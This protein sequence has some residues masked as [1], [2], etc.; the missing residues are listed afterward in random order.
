M[1]IECC[2]LCLKQK[3]VKIAIGKIGYPRCKV[4]FCEEH[5]LETKVLTL[6]FKDNSEKF[7]DFYNNIVNIANNL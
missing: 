7:Y 3:I 5:K 1:K 6:Q 4:H 2:D